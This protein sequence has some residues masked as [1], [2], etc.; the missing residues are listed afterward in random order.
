MIELLDISKSFGAKQVLR[1]L[2]LSVL[3]GETLVVLG[4]S[5]CG[6]SVLLKLI[7]GL[8]R[9]DSGKIIIDGRDTSQI[10]EEGMA[11][12]RRKFGMLFQGGALFD[13]L[14]VGENVAYPLREHTNLTD[15]QV[16]RKVAEK[17]ALVEMEGTEGLMPSD[18]SGGMKK[19]VALARA[20]ALEPEYILYDEPTTGLDPITAERIN[21]LIRRMQSR[22][23]VTS[24]VVTHEI[25]SAYM[26]ADRLAMIYE[27]RILTS[28][29]VE[30]LKRTEI[31]F[32]R[33]F[34]S[35]QVGEK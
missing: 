7:L 16:G 5:G 31:P 18:L 21:R 29:T 35:N 1:G 24:V 10:S 13:S 27:G 6:K 20:L 22:F 9:Q 4:R 25:R 8:M 32:V 34:I 28:G 23:G 19:R 12:V 3:S 2:T 15:A 26:V 14:T 17:L 30:E 11:Q 33:E